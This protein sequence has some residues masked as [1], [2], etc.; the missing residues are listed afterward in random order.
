MGAGRCGCRWHGSNI[1]RYRRLGGPV[2][3]AAGALWWDEGRGPIPDHGYVA[4]VQGGHRFDA[5]NFQ[6]ETIRRRHKRKM[7]F[8]HHGSRH[9]ATRQ[10]PPSP[11]GEAGAG[12][13]LQRLGEED[14]ALVAA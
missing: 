5:P 8:L 4:V 9:V 1:R 7:K 3:P 10:H 11:V 14:G 13:D 2:T 12:D 6:H